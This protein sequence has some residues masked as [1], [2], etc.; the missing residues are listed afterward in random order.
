[1][2]R[3]QYFA[4]LHGLIAAAVDAL[5]EHRRLGATP[6]LLNEHVMKK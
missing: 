3:T 5:E 4:S 1:M 6:Q 2:M